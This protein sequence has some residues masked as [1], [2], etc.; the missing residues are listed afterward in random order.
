MAGETIKEFLVAL[1]FK[2]DDASFR[3]FNSQIAKA[4]VPV[5]QLGTA[6]AAVTLEVEVMVERVAR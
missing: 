1:G 4:T 3:N 2:V 6:V 5:L